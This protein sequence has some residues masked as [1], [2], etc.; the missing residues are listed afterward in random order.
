MQPFWNLRDVEVWI[1]TPD[2]RKAITA[3]TAQEVQ[4]M[5]HVSSVYMFTL[6]ILHVLPSALAILIFQP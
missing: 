4:S 1:Q 2:F 6:L 5:Q 3:F